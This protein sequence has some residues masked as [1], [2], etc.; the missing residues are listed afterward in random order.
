MEEDYIEIPTTREK[1][2]AYIMIVLGLL[3]GAIL[4]MWV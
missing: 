4:G 1:L 3:I 2:V